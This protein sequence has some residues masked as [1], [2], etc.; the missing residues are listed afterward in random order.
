MKSLKK[1]ITQ[2]EIEATIQNKGILR[3]LKAHYYRL[4]FFLKLNASLQEQLTILKEINRIIDAKVSIG[5]S[6]AIDGLRSSVE[7]QKK[8][9]AVFKVQKTIAYQRI[10]LKEL[11]ANTLPED[12]SINTAFAFTPMPDIETKIRQMI[13]TSPLIRQKTNQVE[14]A[15][16]E[17]KAAGLSILEGFE[18]FA[19]QEQEAEGKKW[20]VGIGVEIPL[21]NQKRAR[22]RKAKYMK[23]KSMLELEHTRSHFFADIQQALSD[24]RI[25]EKEIDTFKGAILK[26]G[27]ENMKLSERLYREGEV[28]LVI[29]LDSQNSY[30][31]LLERYYEAITEWCVLK[32]ELESL[33][34][35]EL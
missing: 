21:F 8:K 3:D 26:E 19:E 14:K 4:R 29:F 24:I 35:E 9:T 2:A 16:A 12:F 28:P 10:K 32:A 34:G 7:I 5:E 13:A 31:E 11:L 17:S 22:V 6:K 1:D 18:I 25:L 33:L 27:Q 30:F 15:K 23:R 20:T